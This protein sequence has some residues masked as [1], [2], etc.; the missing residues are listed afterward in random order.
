[1]KMAEGYE[2]TVTSSDEWLTADGKS[3]AR[4]TARVTLGGQ[5]VEGHEVDFGVS[6]GAGSLRVVR[7]QTDRGGEA[8]AVFTAGKKIGIAV[9]TATDRT[10][11]ISGTVRIELRSDAPAKIAITLD[12]QKLPADGRSQ[13]ELTVLVTDIN[14]NPNEGNEVEYAIAAGGGR[15]KSE[16]GLTDRRGESTN[17]YTAGRTP[18]KVTIE[19]TVRSLPPT[20][21]EVLKARDLALAVTDH[22]FF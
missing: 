7:G 12:P 22:R 3:Q 17:S 19:I 16:R 4:I 14:D 2:I 18:G 9:I 20:D 1:M 8:R 13:A 15:L 5:P 10:A 21:E 6:P 11:G